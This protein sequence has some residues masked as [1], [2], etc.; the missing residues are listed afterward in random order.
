MNAS[1]CSAGER[2]EMTDV[3]VSKMTHR[4]ISRNAFGHSDPVEGSVPWRAGAL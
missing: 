2:T 3:I 1:H 4:L